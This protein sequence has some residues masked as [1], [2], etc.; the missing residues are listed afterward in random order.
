M[1]TLQ[2][3]ATSAAETTEE[4]AIK[5]IEA[6][7]TPEQ[8]LS[9]NVARRRRTIARKRSSSSKQR[10][11]TP[12]RD[13]V[14]PI[15]TTS[16]EE[17]DDDVEDEATRLPERPQRKVFAS[18]KPKEDEPKPNNKMISDS[19][20]P[21]SREDDKPKTTDSSF[22]E[23]ERKKPRRI[24][25]KTADSKEGSLS[26]KSSIKYHSERS[27]SLPRQFEEQ[28]S[29]LDNFVSSNTKD[30]IGFLEKAKSTV[31]EKGKELRKKRFNKKE[32]LKRS[33]S[34]PRQLTEEDLLE[35]FKRAQIQTALRE[36][37][38]SKSAGRYSSASESPERPNRKQKPIVIK[39]K[40]KKHQGIKSNKIVEILDPK[41][42]KVIATKDVGEVTHMRVRDVFKIFRFYSIREIF[43]E[44][45]KYKKD[46][47]VEYNKIRMYR[48]KCF[49]HLLILLIFCGLG[50]IVFK[51]TEGAFESFYKCGVKRVKRDFVE[52]LWVKSHNLR[53]DEWKSLARNKL[54]NFEDELHA[55]HEAGVHSYSGQKSWSFLNGIVYCLTIVTTI[56]YGHLYPTTTTGQ[57]LT[58]VYSLIGIPLFLI[59]LTDFGKLF[60]RC[61]KFLW[62]F[63]RRVYYTG[64]C[65]NVRKQAQVQEIF[66]GAQMMYDIARFRRPS[67]FDP[68]MQNQDG[69]EGSNTA[70]PTPAISNFE[71]DDEFNLPISLAIL[72]LVLY[73]FLGAVLF[74]IWEHWDF[75]TS[76]Y[77][78]FISMSTIG[79]GDY[80]PRHPVFMIVSIVY[81]VFGLALMSMCINVVQVKLSDTFSHASAKIGATIGLGVAEEDG[82]IQAIPP[83]LVEMPQ[84]HGSLTQINEELKE[85]TTSDQK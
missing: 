56:G 9:A 82:S 17:E 40:T 33:R 80:V 55:A 30:L 66:K 28:L 78:V 3:S 20:C 76:F 49:S 32:P 81:L 48:R 1:D 22:K 53:E 59:I 57:A 44:Y 2:T 72:L 77:F 46:F 35:S 8:V 68:S 63:V 73:I 25:R 34:T 19:S 62:S 45:R 27:A 4:D 11:K 84:V 26:R 51:F 13:A 16:S 6:L 41:T 5:N 67:A 64:S 74:C 71:I 12:V 58:I 85:P 14:A 29:K 21:S 43:S 37:E 52:M 7:V 42:S 18:D 31:E 36:K 47:A 83:V 70:P 75:F 65:R 79:F 54:R 24:R 23:E 50:G 10:S 60:T 15:G 38:R 69:T 39:P 61:I